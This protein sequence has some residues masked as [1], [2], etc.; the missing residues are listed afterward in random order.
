MSGEDTVPLEFKLQEKDMTGNELKAL[1]GSSPNDWQR[2]FYD[3]YKSYVYTIVFNRLRSCASRED[4]EECVCDVF[5]DVYLSYDE[6]RDV[7]G[8][9]PKY[10]DDFKEIK[11]ADMY[12]TVINELIAKHHEDE[13]YIDLFK[14]QAINFE[15]KYKELDGR[16]ENR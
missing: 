10:N 9:S 8:D 1:T 11:A 6:Y 2:L 12:S 14:D 13:E 7:S 5:V 3:E 16:Y 4:I 15:E